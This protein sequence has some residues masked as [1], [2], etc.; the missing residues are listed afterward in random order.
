MKLKKE[1]FKSKK[2]YKMYK[3]NYKCAARFLKK[4]RTSDI[5]DITYHIASPEFKNT[6]YI[7]NARRAK[8]R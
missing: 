3:D 8:L 2:Y 6:Y 5:F 7:I 1:D 4:A